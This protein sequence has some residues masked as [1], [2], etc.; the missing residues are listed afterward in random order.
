MNLYI[1]FY[2]FLIKK[3]KKNNFIIYNNVLNLKNSKTKQII[4]GNNDV[5]SNETNIYEYMYN[6]TKNYNNYK[7]LQTLENDNIS[8]FIKITKINNHYNKLYISNI[9]GGGLLDDWNF[10]INQ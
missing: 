9:Y 6:F 7:L 5:Q 8:T 4:S 2:L 3:Y 1:Y 10:D